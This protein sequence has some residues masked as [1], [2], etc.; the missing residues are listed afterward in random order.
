MAT[1][2]YGDDWQ[3]WSWAVDV[4]G[5]YPAEEYAKDKGTIRR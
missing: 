2:A 5:T 1:A 4:S 3:G